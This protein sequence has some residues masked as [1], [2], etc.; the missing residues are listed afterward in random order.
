MKYK[1]FLFALIATG[2]LTGCGSAPD[3]SGSYITTVNARS[4]S[5]AQWHGKA[6]VLLAQ[7]GQS[8]T[9]SVTL[10]HPTAGAIQIPITS[11]SASG[12]KVV[13]FGHA[14][15]PLGSLDLSFHGAEKNGC[16]EGGIHLTLHSL[17][18]NETDSAVLLL[19]KARA[20]RN[21]QCAG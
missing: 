21:R 9:G 18:G 6:E 12:G 3:V 13:F 8:L 5:G 16:I 10:H 2:V 1:L 20:L 11:G 19:A 7:E 4:S 14:G 17:F 15:L